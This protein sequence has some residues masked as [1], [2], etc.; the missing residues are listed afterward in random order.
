[1]CGRAAQSV[2]AACMA[3]SALGISSCSSDSGGGISVDEG[4]GTSN[5]RSSVL[6]DASDNHHEWRDNYNMSPGMDAMVFVKDEDSGSLQ[7]KRMSWGL[8]T[9]SGT[10]RNPL[11]P[12]GKER[13]AMHFSNL[14]FNARTD[15]L[16]EKPTFSRLASKGQSCVVALDGYFE[17]KAS[18]LAGGKGKK[19]PYF[20]HRKQH[21]DQTSDNAHKKGDAEQSFLLFAG[22]W[23]RVKTGIKDEPFLDTF[24]ILT[25][26][27]SSSIEWLH[28]RMPVGIFN[29][30][31]A[32]QWLDQPT[33]KLHNKLDHEARNSDSFEWHM[34][35]TD[36]SSVKFRDKTAIKAIPKP[37][38]VMSFFNKTGGS[39]ST[40][41]TSKKGPQKSCQAE[42]TSESALKTSGTRISDKDSAKAENGKRGNSTSALQGSA[43]KKAKASPAKKGSI[44][45]FFSPKKQN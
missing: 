16:F 11:P 43:N 41:P 5:D 39:A 29:L 36:M 37:R 12:P 1:M 34:V 27:A 28:H 32:R 8:I 23:T 7:M 26:E 14:M 24:T 2:R 45:S 4:S 20:V 33:T 25:T 21:L 19:Q 15:T 9:K 40:N 30:E 3:A 35:T 13:M 10:E 31:Y 22:L 44:T 18:P 38:S 6:K 42:V 17:W